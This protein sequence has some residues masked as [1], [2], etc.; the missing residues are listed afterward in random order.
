MQSLS[1]SLVIP[2]LFL[3]FS[4]QYCA[5]RCHP[6]AICDLWPTLRTVS[7]SLSLSER[8]AFSCIGLQSSGVS[9]RGSKRIIADRTA[10]T[11]VTAPAKPHT[12]WFCEKFGSGLHVFSSS[13]RHRFDCLRLYLYLFRSLGVSSLIFSLFPEPKRWEKSWLSVGWVEPRVYIQEYKLVVQ[14]LNN[15]SRFI[16]KARLVRGFSRYKIY[17]FSIDD[18]YFAIVCRELLNASAST[19]CHRL[20]HR[21]IRCVESLLERHQRDIRRTAK[22]ISLVFCFC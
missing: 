19:R 2:Q 5:I 11:A 1:H 3:C 13:L 9:G 15:G 7:L 21:V 4:M 17:I 18:K 12:K 8:Q 10:L 16:L 6:N 20:D 22:P 14:I